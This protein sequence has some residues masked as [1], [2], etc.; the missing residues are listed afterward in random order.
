MVYEYKVGPTLKNNYFGSLGTHPQS[1]TH[2]DHGPADDLT[3]LT[4]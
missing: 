4:L 1:T 2:Y 3:L